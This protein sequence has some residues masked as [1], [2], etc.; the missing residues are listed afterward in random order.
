MEVLHAQRDPASASFPSLS[1]PSG[2]RHPCLQLP[3][4]LAAESSQSGT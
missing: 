4:A 3:R 1:A 2:L